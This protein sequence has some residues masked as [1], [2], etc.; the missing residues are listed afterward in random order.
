MVLFIQNPIEMTSP[1]A[2]KELRI[3]DERRLPLST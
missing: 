2:Y 3:Q 1:D